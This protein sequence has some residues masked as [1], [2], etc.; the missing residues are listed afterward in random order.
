[1]VS[2]GGREGRVLT[3]RIEAG[4]VCGLSWLAADAPLAAL[5]GSAACL[6]LQPRERGAA[7]QLVFALGQATRRR[8]P[9]SGRVHIGARSPLTGGYT[10]GAVGGGLAW[11]LAALFGEDEPLAVLAIEAAPGLS[12]ERCVLHLRRHCD[13]EI[14]ASLVDAPPA[15]GAA[16]LAQALVA[17]RS[18]ASSLEV[19]AIAAGPGAERGVPYGILVTGDEVP[20]TTGRG[21]LGTALATLGLVGILVEAPRLDSP[22]G[23]PPAALAGAAQASPRLKERAA[24]G[25]LEL[26][27][28]FAT[29][30]DLWSRNRRERMDSSAAAA[31]VHEAKQA[32]VAHHG[33]RGCPTP[34]GL[35]FER[36]S[37]RRGGARFG[38]TYAL[39]PNLGFTGEGAFGAALALLADCDREGLDARE[40][41]ACLALL[42]RAGELGIETGLA[43]VGFG[44][45]E[46]LGAALRTLPPEGSAAL[47]ERLG[48]EGE[49]FD[50]GGQVARPEADLAS[51]L[52][53]VVATAGNDPM[54]SFPFLV[55]RPGAEARLLDGTPLEEGA[56]DPRSPVGKGLLVAWHEDLAAALDIVGFCS[57]STAGLLVDGAVELDELADWIAPTSVRRGAGSGRRFIELGRRLVEARRELQREWSGPLRIPAWARETLARPGMLDAYLAERGEA[58]ELDAAPESHRSEVGV[59][60]SEPPALRRGRVVVAATGALG[61][62]LGGEGGADPGSRALEL[63]LPLEAGRVLEALV[64]EEPAL[65]SLI[66]DRGGRLLPSLWRRGE[67]LHQ[68]ELVFD[69]ERLEL[70]LVIGGG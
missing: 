1:M 32:E 48:L 18:S 61:E 11:A 8:L 40:A 38:A 14:E 6:A 42:A 55:T 41:G 30:G 67:P 53:Q 44:D 34:C 65:R 29:R 35:V 36:P 2:D 10:E 39:G 63:E 31:L 68:G 59:R 27:T 4:G 60:G 25:T 28:A 3:L 50:V 7:P 62:A 47:A 9:S 33:C 69:G 22:P 19:A 13:G 51:T 66:F 17:G 26:F 16:S 46:S 12:N 21:G 23:K 54:R 45:T 56:L 58:P 57:F 70:L 37:G 52:G 24:G 15:R 20:V 64:L 49:S 43:R 5:G